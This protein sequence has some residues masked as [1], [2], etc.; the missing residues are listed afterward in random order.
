L[1]AHSQNYS[2]NVIS[3]DYS[4]CFTAVYC[5]ACGTKWFKIGQTNELLGTK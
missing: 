3:V 1:K 4:M 2:W 5:S